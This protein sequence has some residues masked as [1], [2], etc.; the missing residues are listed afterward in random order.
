MPEKPAQGSTTEVPGGGAPTETPP[1][2]A[3]IYDDDEV[4]RLVIKK[5]SLAEQRGLEKAR[6][7]LFAKLGV[8][9]EDEAAALTEHGRKALPKVESDDAKTIA[10]LKADHAAQLEKIEKERA[11]LQRIADRSTI[12]EEARKHLGD[13]N[14]PELF[15]ARYGFQTPSDLRIEV[16]DGHPVFVDRHGVEKDFA[17]TLKAEKARPELDYWIRSNGGGSG[18]RTASPAKG[19]TPTIDTGTA[20]ATTFQDALRRAAAKS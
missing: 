20:K 19:A 5:E 15:L 10:K 7:A 16:K 4:N 1:A 13:V 6:A 17:K 2:K 14:D 11:E 12:L 3:K 8:A 18:T 9:N